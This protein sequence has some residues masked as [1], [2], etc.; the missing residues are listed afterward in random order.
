M[1]AA[2]AAQT[3]AGNA[4]TTADSAQSAANANASDL[5]NYITSNNA[6]IEN[7]QG[8]IDGAITTWFY[9]VPPANDNPPANQWTT[10]DMKNIHLGDLYYDTITGYCYRW[11]VQNNQYSWQRITDTDV[12]KALEDAAEAQDTADAKRRVFV[13]QPVPP[14]EIG[15][16][17]VQGATGDIL[18]C[19]TTKTAQQSFSSS[20]W[21]LASKYTDNTVANAAQEAAENAQNTADNAQAAA[22]ENAEAIAGLGT[23]VTT[24][25]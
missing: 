4:Q 6:E 15:D 13:T 24:V 10:T 1:A 22:D 2:N 25:E 5:A 17:W 20:D 9:E 21:V 16:L 18:R 12:T 19:N 23:R 8:Q 3:A 11:Q 7:L 14:Y